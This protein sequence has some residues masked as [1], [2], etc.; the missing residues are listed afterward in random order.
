MLKYAKNKLLLVSQLTAFLP[1]LDRHSAS[2]G[3]LDTFIG[4]KSGLEANSKTFRVRE[5]IQVLGGAEVRVR[6]LTP[7]SQGLGSGSEHLSKRPYCETVFSSEA[8]HTDF[9]SRGHR[10]G[11]ALC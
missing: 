9:E 3:G 2:C 4:L 7:D 1:P 8:I 10:W 5:L 6:P 11:I